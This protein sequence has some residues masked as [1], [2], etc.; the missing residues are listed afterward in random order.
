MYFENRILCFVMLLVFSTS[1]SVKEERIACPCNLYLAMPEPVPGSGIV[2]WEMSAQSFRD[3]GVL[4]YEMWPDGFLFSVP[5]SDLRVDMLL[6]GNSAEFDGDGM[7]IPEGKDCPYVYSYAGTLNCQADE[8]RE[9]IVL[10][11]KYA[12]LYCYARRDDSLTGGVR[13]EVTGNVRGYTVTAAPRAGNFRYDLE[14]KQLST[15]QVAGCVS[16]PAQVDGSLRLN[17]VSQDG[18]LL[19][20]FAVGEYIL[21]SGY[22]WGAEDLADIRIEVDIVHSSLWL[23][24]SGKV[25]RYFTVDL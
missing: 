25:T 20:S 1:C 10:H 15:S 13:F 6:V 23:Y 2:A 16:L 4:S 5:K 14:M 8:E 3:S 12:L 7:V 24:S 19:R 21:R 22:N 9:T 11:K 18:S 17:V